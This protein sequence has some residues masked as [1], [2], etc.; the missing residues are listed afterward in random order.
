[1][2]ALTGAVTSW[3]AATSS[4]IQDAED[5]RFRAGVHPGQH[6][7]EAQQAQARGQAQQRTG[8]QAD[9]GDDVGR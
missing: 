3:K 9:R 2:W 5:L 6:V 7:R 1:M 4:S 8:Q